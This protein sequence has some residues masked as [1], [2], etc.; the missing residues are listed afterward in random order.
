MRLKRALGCVGADG[1]DAC[2][3]TLLPSPAMTA[4][5]SAVEMLPWTEPSSCTTAWRAS[6]RRASASVPTRR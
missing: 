6:A 3:M 1:G 5:S 2:S 4:C